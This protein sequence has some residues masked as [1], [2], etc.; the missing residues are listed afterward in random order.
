MAG[1]VPEIIQRET[2]A[3]INTNIFNTPKDSLPPSIK[4]LNPSLIET[5]L[6]L[7]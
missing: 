4:Y 7:Q 6:L 5:P 1:T 2:I 3:P